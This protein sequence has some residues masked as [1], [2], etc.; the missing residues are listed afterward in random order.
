MFVGGAVDI[1][2]A[3]DAVYV[4]GVGDDAAAD[5]IGD[6]V[7]PVCSDS[8]ADFAGT[9]VADFSRGSAGIAACNASA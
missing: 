4:G 1:G 6:E 5:I 3:D 2:A 9:G 8:G 7:V